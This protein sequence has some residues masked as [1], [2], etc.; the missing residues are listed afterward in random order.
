M[1]KYT[2]NWND[3]RVKRRINTSLDYAMACLSAEK[4][5]AWGT[6]HIDHWFGNQGNRLSKMIRQELLKCSN[7]YYNPLTGKAKQYLLNQPG[8]VKLADKIGRQI[9]PCA[10]HLQQE[11]IRCA[12]RLYG[13]TIASGAFE[14]TLK[15]SRLWNDIQNL[16]ND[17]RKPLFANYGYVNEYDI[18]SAAPQILYQLARHSG[19]TR[20]TPTVE[21]YLAD[22]TQHRQQLA[23]YLAV[24][25]K[26]AKQLITSRFAGARFGQD[27]SLFQ[28]LNRSWHKHTLLKQDP[29]FEQLS[30]DIKKIWDAIKQSESQGR[31]TARTKWGIYFREELRVMRSV[32]RYLDKTSVRYFHEHDGWR[33]D[34][35]I[36]LRE[37]KLHVKKQTDY[38]LEFDWELA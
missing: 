31:M 6:R 8:A 15:S 30:K 37:L 17:T 3:P 28:Q 16:D 38:W 10:L 11:K 25:V 23:Q 9:I 14:Y 22:P 13:E 5:K 34:S 21:C 33:C 7:P 26:C 20:P 29:W 1:T 18:K 36:D 27:N 24:D 19:M 12:D 2:P 4:P 32:H 35:A